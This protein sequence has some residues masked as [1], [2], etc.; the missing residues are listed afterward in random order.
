MKQPLCYD[1]VNHLGKREE[2]K[3]QELST[4]KFGLHHLPDCIKDHGEEQAFSKV[5]KVLLLDCWT[6]NESPTEEQWLWGI[7]DGFVSVLEKVKVEG[8]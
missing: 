6:R 1:Q 7:K 8:R 4:S 3:V 2:E 5:K